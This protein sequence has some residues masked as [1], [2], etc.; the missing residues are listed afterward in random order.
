MPPARI[1]DPELY[2]T[3]AASIRG[4][5]VYMLNILRWYAYAKMYMA[6]TRIGTLWV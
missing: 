4:N 3:Q 2:L 1:R 6:L 5:M